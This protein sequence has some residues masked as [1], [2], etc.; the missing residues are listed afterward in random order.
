M[1]SRERQLCPIPRVQR[2]E[3][4]DWRTLVGAQDPCAPCPHG[5]RV[6]TFLSV[7]LGLPFVGPLV[8][9]TATC[10]SD[11]ND[12][13]S[14]TCHPDPAVRDPIFSSAPFFGA[15]GRA[16]EGSRFSFHR[17]QDN[18]VIPTG[19]TRLLLSRGLCAPGLSSLC[20]PDPAR[21]DPIFSSAPLFGASGRAVEGSWQDLNLF[22]IDGIIPPNAPHPSPGAP[23][24]ES[25]PGSWVS[26]VAQT[27]LSVLLGLPFVGTAV[28][29]RPLF[30]QWS[31]D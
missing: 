18:G 22:A 30:S 6:L 15:S 3:S 12:P 17:D 19:A 26:L 20:H 25:V 8:A 1:I 7:L 5:L 28:C 23:G 9:A 11:R 29:G 24:T 13:T 2:D 14:A 4:P 21:R 27:F 10:Q 16:V 31:H